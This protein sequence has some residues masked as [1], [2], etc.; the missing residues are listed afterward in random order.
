MDL[1]TARPEQQHGQRQ[2]HHYAA[3]RYLIRGGIRVRIRPARSTA[4]GLWLASLWQTRPAERSG[5]RPPRLRWPLAARRLGRKR[6][7]TPATRL[8]TATATSCR[9]SSPRSVASWRRLSA[10][11]LLAIGSAWRS[12]SELSLAMPAY[13]YT[14]DQVPRQES[15]G[16]SALTDRGAAAGVGTHDAELGPQGRPLPRVA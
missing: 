6:A 10:A 8:Q 7:P 12:Q 5:Q 4:A 14:C 13:M 3:Q 15:R 9:Q 2:V 16:R 1:V 11:S